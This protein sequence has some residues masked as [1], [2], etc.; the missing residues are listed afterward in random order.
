MT[1]LTGG[2]NNFKSEYEEEGFISGEGG[3]AHPQ[4]PPP[5]SAP[6]GA[7]L[8]SIKRFVISKGLLSEVLE[9]V[10]RGFAI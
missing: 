2:V 8:R 3:G 6:E 10:T 9:F 4:Q 7:V 1:S 5:S